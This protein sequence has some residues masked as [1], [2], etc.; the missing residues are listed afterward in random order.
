MLARD[1][2]VQKTKQ[3]VTSFVTATLV[4]NCMNFTAQ[5]YQ[6]GCFRGISIKSGAIL[7][8]KH[9]LRFIFLAVQSLKIILRAPFLGMSTSLTKYIDERYF[10]EVAQSNTIKWIY[11]LLIYLKCAQTELG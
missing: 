2:H 7:G 3:L 4:I 9:S 6:N 11:F 1:E 10:I 5:L 8:L